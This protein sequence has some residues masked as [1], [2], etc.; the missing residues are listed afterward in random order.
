MNDFI[1]HNNTFR[2]I[3]KLKMKWY[4]FRQFHRSFSLAMKSRFVKNDS[5]NNTTTV[6]LYIFLSV[7]LLQAARSSYCFNLESNDERQV[8]DILTNGDSRSATLRSVS[9]STMERFSTDRGNYL[10]GYL[11]QIFIDSMS[12]VCLHLIFTNFQIILSIRWTDPL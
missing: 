11:I 10:D 6:N 12:S 1:F 9:S 3:Y 2:D 5:I 7:K 8:D 4:S